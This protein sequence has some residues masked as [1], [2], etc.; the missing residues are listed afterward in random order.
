[1]LIPMPI[2]RFNRVVTNRIT[3]P[4]APYLPGFGVIVHTGRKTG[5]QYRTPVNVFRSPGGFVVALTYGPDAQWVRNVMASGGCLLET[6]GRTLRITRPRL[7][8]D[9]QRR[10]WPAFVRIV[11]GLVNVS[12][13]LELSVEDGAGDQASCQTH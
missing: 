10:S 11:L 5:A 9:E 4:L 7:F 12:D 13:F 1:M 2:A 6:R 8:H 3:G